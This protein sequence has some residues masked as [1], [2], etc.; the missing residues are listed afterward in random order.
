[1]LVGWSYLA[2]GWLAGVRRPE[3]RLGIVMLVIGLTWFAGR[4]LRE[5]HSPL[6]F[7]AGVWLSDLWFIPF[8]WLVAA[9]PAGRLL[10]RLDRVLFGTI[11]FVAAPL[12]ALWLTF[13]AF[14]PQ[15]PANA[16]LISAN[17]DVASALDTVQRVLV[18]S[19]M[20]GLAVVLVRRWLRA[21]RLLRRV[22]YPVLAGAVGLGVTSL[23]LLL[24]KAGVLPEW[25]TYVGY[26][27][28]AAVPLAFLAG[29][30]RARLAR[31]SIGDLLVDLREPAAPG[32]LRD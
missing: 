13:L 1:M 5:S 12:E 27:V 18:I 19:A 15:V 7:T 2:S 6:L 4:V 28:L 16:L 26:A 10:T 14:P 25:M 20:S 24:D 29:A 17:A 32:A 8:A 31:S 23:N 21:S 30:L 22:L 11:V 3:N 9:F